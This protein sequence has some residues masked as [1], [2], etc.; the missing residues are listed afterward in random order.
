MLTLR[1]D[2]R[3]IT[4]GAIAAD[5]LQQATTPAL[6]GLLGCN[7]AGATVEITAMDC[8]GGER[9]E[10]EVVT[11]SE[12]TWQIRDATFAYLRT[13]DDDA[14]TYCDELAAHSRMLVVM[15]PPNHQAIFTRACQSMLGRR[16]PIIWPIDGFISYRM[17]L[18]PPTLGVPKNRVLRELLVRCNRRTTEAHCDESIL[19]DIPAD[20]G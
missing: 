19:I 2:W 13:V 11:L 8:F 16:T 20:L 7:L 4:W 18:T 17:V 1:Q 6:K 15:V 5:I 10:S 14:L 9:F 3:L 12:S